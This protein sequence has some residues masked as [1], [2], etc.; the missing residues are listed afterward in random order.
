MT[1]EAQAKAAIERGDLQTAAAAAKDLVRTDPGRPAGYFL[2]G[3]IAA[4]AGQI[5]RAIPLVEAAVERGP[6][7]EHL[8]QLA[9]LLILLRRDG[10]AAEIAEIETVMRKDR[11]AYDG[12]PQMQA[13]Y[14]ELLGRKV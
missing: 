13:R 9:R 6:E 2:L 14:R 4:E 7:A 5:A 11:R 10:E 1:L 8:A 3:M 12:D